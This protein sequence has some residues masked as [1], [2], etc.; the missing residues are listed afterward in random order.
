MQSLLCAI[1]HYREEGT[2]PARI[3]RLWPI[4]WLLAALGAAGHKPCSMTRAMPAHAS[5]PDGL[6]ATLEPDWP[7]WRGPRRDGIS[8][9][10]GLLPSW[11][12]GGPKLLW[13]IG[14]LGT[15]WSSL[16]VKGGP[17]VVDE[18]LY[19]TGDVGNDLVVFALD[20]DGA[21]PPPTR[22]AHDDMCGSKRMP[23]PSSW[24]YSTR[25]RSMVTPVATSSAK[26]NAPSMST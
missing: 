18:R 11:P 20:L 4:L 3:M 8:D 23:H 19:I 26:S 9:E 5:T 2:G 14:G 7:Q 15:G 24:G 1:G 6:I 16:S 25:P 21:G 12:Q 13:K 17:I 10:K 22:L